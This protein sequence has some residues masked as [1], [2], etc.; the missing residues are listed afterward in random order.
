MHNRVL[1]D[2]D[3]VETY[4]SAGFYI[5]ESTAEQVNRGTVVAVGPGKATKDGAV[6]PIDIKVDERVLF[7]PG[8]G[9][10]VTVEGVE[11]LVIDADEVVAIAD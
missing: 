11:Y 4:T 5:P 1:V 9:L 7:V 10:K 8:T 2:C 6:I 3:P